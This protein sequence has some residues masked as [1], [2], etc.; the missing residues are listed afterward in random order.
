MVK[1]DEIL[2]FDVFLYTYIYIYYMDLEKPER[3]RLYQ[4]W[5]GSNRFLLGGRLVFGPDVASLFLT[6]FLIAGP[7]L[8]FCIK[9]LIVIKHELKEH[10]NAVPWY[11]V[12]V[13]AIVLTM[14][15]IFFLFLTSSRDPGIVPRSLKPPESDESIEINT[16]SMEWVNGRTPHLKLPRTK[17]VRN[18]R[19]FYMFISTST[20]LCIYVFSVSWYCIVHRSGNVLK[21][22]SCDILSDV[23]IVYC[24]IAVW[25]VGGLTVFHFYLISTNQ[26][27]YE[28]FRY[29]YDKKENP[30]NRGM[31]NNFKEVFFSKIPPSMN[32]FRS[33]VEEDE[34]MVMEPTDHNF[35]DNIASSKEKIDI[36]MGSKFADENGLMIPD[37]LRNLEYD[38]DIE[39][40]LKHKEWSERSD[41]GQLIFPVE[42][43][44]K[45]AMSS[46]TI[47]IEANEEEK[48]DECIPEIRE[49]FFG[50]SFELKSHDKCIPEIRER[51]FGSSFE[52]KSHDKEPESLDHL[53]IRCPIAQQVWLVSK[54]NFRLLPFEHLVIEDWIRLLLSMDRHLISSLELCWEFLTFSVIAMGL[55]WNARN[56]LC[57]EF[58]PVDVVKI[59]HLADKL[60]IEHVKAQRAKLLRAQEYNPV[61]K[62]R[63]PPFDW[64]KVNT[65][66]SFK[67]GLCAV[68]ILI[69]DSSGVIV[70]AAG[71]KSWAHDVVAAETLAIAKALSILDKTG[72][73]QVLFENDSLVAVNLIFH[74]DIL[75]DWTAKLDIEAAK[76]LLSRWPMWHV[77]NISRFKNSAANLDA[78]W[79]FHR[80]WSGIIP[81]NCIL[82]DIFCEESSIPPFVALNYFNF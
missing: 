71:F 79:A 39:E 47:E 48:H 33:F 34:V 76:F 66:A 32:D 75:P 25:F 1:R 78:K 63:A 41:S 80:G 7:A 24:F 15:D 81:H 17:D 22:M 38:D 27:T 46:L 26:T 6:T 74:D 67:D 19:F 29:R 49:R 77:C 28:N 72:V 13:V 60:T 43:E 36:E 65:D 61:Q 23:L 51:F 35:L 18:Y 21:A 45:S 52:L 62:W 44:L 64:L 53:F 82:L 16:P 4:V 50:S 2:D 40:N 69:R 58:I 54:W 5:R 59:A 70:H 42:Q 11:P 14:L 30:Y 31:I 37:I 12:L 10:K 56:K 68:A 8:A 3:K 9:I 57:H 20:I 55:V 73:Y